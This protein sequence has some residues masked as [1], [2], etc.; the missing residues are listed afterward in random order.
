MSISE[1]LPP[2]LIKANLLRRMTGN[3]GEEE[4]KNYN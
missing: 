4:K 2:L 3:K 1:A